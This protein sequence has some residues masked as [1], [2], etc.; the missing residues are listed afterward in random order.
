MPSSGLEMRAPI[1]DTN[2]TAPPPRL[3]HR[4]QRRLDHRRGA[5]EVGLEHRAHLVEVNVLD[6][7]EHGVAGVAHQAAERAAGVLL[8]G[9]DALARPTPGRST[10]RRDDAHA[11][12]PA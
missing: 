12:A 2:T 1:D 4:R 8:G 6:R 9:G 5:E 3:A 10:S 7:A 11:G